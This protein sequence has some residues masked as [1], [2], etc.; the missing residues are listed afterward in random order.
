M[1]ITLTVVV[2]AIV[3]LITALV[4]ITIFGS[5]IANVGT[6]AEAKTVCKTT[7]E[8]TCRTSNVKPQI[9]NV[10]Q[11]GEPKTCDSIV[12]CTCTDYSPVCADI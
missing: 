9:W 12:T 7:Y 6:L 1:N 3:I 11:N 5:G 8:T 4:V 2:A 10:N